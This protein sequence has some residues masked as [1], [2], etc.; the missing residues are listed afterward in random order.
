M[1][2]RLL[3][4]RYRVDCPSAKRHRAVCPSRRLFRPRMDGTRTRVSWTAGIRTQVS[5]RSPG[6]PEGEPRFRPGVPD[7]RNPNPSCAPGLLMDETRT[8]VAPRGVRCETSP[9]G[10]SIGE[11]LPRRLSIQAAFSAPDGQGPNPSFLDGRNPNPG[12]PRVP[13]R[14]AHEPRLRPEAGGPPRQLQ[15]EPRLSSKPQMPNLDPPIPRTSTPSRPRISIPPPDPE[16]RPPAPTAR[17]LAPSGKPNTYRSPTNIYRSRKNTGTWGII[18]AVSIHL[19][20]SQGCYS[21][22]GITC[23]R[24]FGGL[25]ATGSRA[26]MFRGVFSCSS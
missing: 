21:S 12:S 1:L 6:R 11:T 7:G 17:P 24:T 2:L 13:G 19:H 22:G 26:V 18:F 8:L 25:E 15:S 23:A 10:L 5:P 14:A 16:P 9:R 4:K 3:A 20:L